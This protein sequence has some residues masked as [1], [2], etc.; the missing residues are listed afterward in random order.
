MYLTRIRLIK[1]LDLTEG[2]DVAG[3]ELAVEEVVR[4]E[5]QRGETPL[6]LAQLIEQVL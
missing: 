6:V 2:Q 1:Q 5:D 4:V 3:I